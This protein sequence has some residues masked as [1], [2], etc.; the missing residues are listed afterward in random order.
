MAT[1]SHLTIELNQDVEAKLLEL[2]AAT[3]RSQAE[4]ANVALTSYLDRE[5]KTVDGIRRGLADI[6]S[7]DLVDHDKAMD[8]LD[9][10]I[11]AAEAARL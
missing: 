8:E 9:A 7:G 4:L 1:G 2:S 3:D 6:K 11:E 5:L 10:V